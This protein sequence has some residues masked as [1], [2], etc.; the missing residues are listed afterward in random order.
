VRGSRCLLKCHDRSKVDNSQR[1]SLA[2]G[3]RPCFGTQSVRKISQFCPAKVHQMSSYTSPSAPT[4]PSATN[5]HGRTRS[6]ADRSPTDH[7]YLRQLQRSARRQFNSLHD[8]TMQASPFVPAVPDVQSYVSSNMPKASL[9]EYAERLGNAI[10][11]LD[12]E[13]A[14]GPL[15]D[16]A[17]RVSEAI[18]KTKT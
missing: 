12:P 6:S 13:T 18:S 9:A 4:N 1:R 2:L 5:G 7:S 10:S 11:Q 15:I 8:V 3:H 14:A 17:R 16:A